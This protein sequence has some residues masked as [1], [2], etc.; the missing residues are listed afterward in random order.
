VQRNPETGNLYFDIPVAHINPN[1]SDE[2]LKTARTIHLYA[3][4]IVIDEEIVTP[5]KM[6]P[7]PIEIIPNELF[8]TNGDIQSALTQE[9]EQ[10]ANEYQFQKETILKL[11][12]LEK[13]GNMP[14]VLTE[15]IL[16]N[17]DL[18]SKNY[19]NEEFVNYP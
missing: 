8:N 10:V 17:Y 19:P 18:N 13:T 2:G 12:T 11:Q 15:D 5:Q 14:A 6:T 7:R 1:K 4:N 9:K 16:M 3:D